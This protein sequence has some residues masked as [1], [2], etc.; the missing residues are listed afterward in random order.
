MIVVAYG[1][2]LVFLT[3]LIVGD[4]DA[5]VRTKAIEAAAFVCVPAAVFLL[6][7]APLWHGSRSRVWLAV[8]GLLALAVAIVLVVVT[9]GIALPASAGLV[10]VAIADL[11]RVLEL[12]GFRGSRRGLMFAVVLLVGGAL[13]G[14]ALP[15][16]VILAVVGL[17]IVFWKLFA[18]RPGRAA[19]GS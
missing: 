11:D 13:V 1:L 2:A 14:L 6:A 3:A 17:A 5:T 16:A 8:A 18:T 19:D 4:S 12:S 7:A 15:L 10:A 9:W